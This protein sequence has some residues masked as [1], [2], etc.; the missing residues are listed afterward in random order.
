TIRGDIEV[1]NVEVGSQVSQL[2]FGARV[3]GDEP[4]ILMLDLSRSEEHTSELQSRFDLVCRL[5]L[6]KKKN[7]AHARELSRPNRRSTN[8]ARYSSMPFIQE[9]RS[10]ILFIPARSSSP[11]SIAVVATPYVSPNA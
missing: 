3:E 9:T 4:E 2:P 6:E 10:S 11:S 8:R 5:L 7:L 1:A